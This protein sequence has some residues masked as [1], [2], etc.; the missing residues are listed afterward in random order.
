LKDQSKHLIKEVN[1]LK[2]K[3]LWY[4]EISE[5]KGSNLQKAELEV[6]EI[7]NPNFYSSLYCKK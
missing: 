1:L 5:T 4:K 6:I 3:A 2:K 7:S